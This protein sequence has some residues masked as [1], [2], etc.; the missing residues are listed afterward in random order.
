MATTKRKTEKPAPARTVPNSALQVEVELSVELG[1][2]YETLDTILDWSEGS[3][4][5]LHKVNGDMADLRLNGESYG[6][7]EV[8]TIGDNMGFRLVEIVNQ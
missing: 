7:G 3:L 5:E 1:R 4:I 8:V 2:T 6:R